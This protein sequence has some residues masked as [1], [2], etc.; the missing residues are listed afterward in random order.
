MQLGQVRKLP[1]WLL[2]KLGR[3]PSKFVPEFIYPDDTFLVSFPKSGNTWVKFMLA[4]LIRPPGLHI[5]FHSVLH[6]IPEVNRDLDEIKQLARPRIMKSHAPFQPQF[7]K[8][9]YLVRDGRDAYVSYYHY[10]RKQLPPGTTFAQYLAMDDHWPCSWSTHVTSWLDAG[11][12]SGEFL[13]VRY[14]NLHL[15]PKRE[16]RTIA[17]FTNLQVTDRQIREAVNQSSF[18]L[19][20]EVERVKGHPRSERFSGRFVR[21]GQV[22]GWRDHFDAEA[23][24]IFKAKENEALLRLGY[25]SA[26][27][28]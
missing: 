8:V 23:T 7:P 11:L 19:M 28:W 24:S 14:E 15:A 13:L 27:D 3:A 20:K 16:L 9:I 4:H 21:R 12:N 18:E 2:S 5:N 10:R 26:P 25:E 17:S 1:K 22:G 6:V